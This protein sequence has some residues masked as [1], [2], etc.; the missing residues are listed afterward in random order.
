V[1]AD[2]AGA[3]TVV[4]GFVDSDTCGQL[5]RELEF[6]WW[7][8]S[9]VVNRD[10]SGGMV[11]FVSASRTSR[12]A[13]QRYFSDE[14]SPLL[15]A[16]QDRACELFALD[17]CRLE[18]WQAL[19]YTAG[20]HFDEHHDGGLFATEPAGDRR[21]TVL[22]YLDSPV[23]GGQ[24]VFPRLGCAVQPIEGR[25][26]VWHNLTE[27]GRPD[28]LMRHRAEPVLEG[29]KLV[30]TTWERERPFRASTPEVPPPEPE[31]NPHGVGVGDHRSGQGQIRSPSRSGP[32][33]A[34]P[35]RDHPPVRGGFP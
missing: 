4:D 7:R 18:E 32:A 19:H 25:L 24:T 29:Q 10:P 33:P 20:G 27:D 6:T 30:L 13:M 2:P 14:M 17:P 26:V 35:H 28:S 21:T 9:T 12:T 22:L 5:R 1:T 34:G 3:L 11:S 23:R 31:R 8:S 16:I 15:A